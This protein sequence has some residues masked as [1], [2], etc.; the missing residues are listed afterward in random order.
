MLTELTIRDLALIESASLSFQGALNV[1]TG[2]TGAGKSLLIDALELLLGRR[3]RSG[4]IRAGAER[5]RVEGRFVVQGLG[6]VGYGA[7]VEKWLASQL[8]EVLDEWREEREFQGKDGDAEQDL[9][10]ILTRTLSKDGRSSAHVNHRPVTQKVLRELASQLVE[11]H[12]QNDHQR[13]FEAAE[14]RALLDT[15][16][17]LEDALAGYRERRASWLEEAQRL[18]EFESQEAER[19]ERLDLLRFQ[20]SELSD[21]APQTG[22]VLGL[23]DERE[24]LR[25]AGELSTE[26]GGILGS[27]SEHDG[28]A[29]DRVRQAERQLSQWGARVPGLDDAVASLREVSAHLEDAVA[30]LVSFADGVEANPPRLEVVE[31]RLSNLERLMRK[32]RTDGD[33]LAQKHADLS[34]ELDALESA[35]QDRDQLTDEVARR[36]AGVEEAAARLSQGRADLVPRLREAVHGGLEELG[37]ANA[38]FDAALLPRADEVDNGAPSLSVDRKRFGEHGAEDVE[39]L[40]AANPGE[41]SSP[42]REVA[43]GGEAARIMLA[44]RGALAVKQSTPT[45]IFDEVDAG[46]GGRLGPQVAAHLQG[47]GAVHQILCVT[48]LAPIAARAAH[49]LRVAKSVEDGRTRTR[50]QALAGDDRM[51]EVADMISGGRDQATALAEARRLLAAQ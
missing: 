28:A 43:S 30:N 32:F 16:G 1:I 41:P 5:A 29:L 36:R 24:L 22:E 46:V 3:A 26:L 21:L 20:I 27:L 17:G 50:V 45:L 15:F 7:Q 11:I 23:Q 34:Q 25:H 38:Q 8:P 13:L 6:R 4:L 19:L 39:F 49:H 44:L 47:L 18:E 51:A 48:H 42:L 37:L 14:Q 33:G 12:G 35:Q 40:L 9:E 10:L 31:E 2:E